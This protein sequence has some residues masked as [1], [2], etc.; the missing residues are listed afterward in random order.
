[1]GIRS[2]RR[3]VEVNREEARK[4]LPIIQAFAEGKTIQV[5]IIGRDWEDVAVDGFGSSFSFN[6]ENYR[7][8]PEPR[9]IYVNEYDDACGWDAAYLS[10]DYALKSAATKCKRRAIKYIEAEDQS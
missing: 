1:M 3:R 5:L 6:P 10:K 4:L 7:I 9:V 2:N 8:K